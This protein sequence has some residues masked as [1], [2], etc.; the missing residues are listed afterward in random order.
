MRIGQISLLLTVTGAAI[1]GAEPGDWNAVT[2]APRGAL[3][4][5]I[6]GGLKRATGVL[7]EA[8]AESVT[9]RTDAGS[10]SFARANVRRLSI[11]KKSRKKRA[12]L[13][14]AIGAGAGAAAMALSA[15]VGDI[16]IRRDI[17]VGVGAALG[18]AAGAGFGALSGGPETIYRAP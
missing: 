18:A 10:S 15:N 2:Q 12:L 7:M 9:I 6:H 13:G 11:V 16:D 14:A 1:T 8:T 3:V 4:E 5:V 17:V